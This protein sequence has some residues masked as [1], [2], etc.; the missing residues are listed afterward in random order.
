MQARPG[1]RARHVAANP[2]VVVLD[3]RTP[4]EFAEG[5]LARAA[6]VNFNA[7]DFRDQIAQF[8]RSA[9]YLVY[10]HSGNR[11]AQATAIM[12]Q[13]GFVRVNELD[14]GIAAWQDA[15]GPVVT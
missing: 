3:V 8:D 10:C 7:S 15:H 13:L 14:G 9:I 1:H 12:A 5:H 2:S 4:A 11:S 6:L